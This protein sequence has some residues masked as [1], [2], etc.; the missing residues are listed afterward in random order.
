[1]SDEL[2]PPK[3]PPVARDLPSL[4]AGQRVLVGRDGGVVS[5]TANR[6]RIA[7]NLSLVAVG[8]A[9]LIVFNPVMGA[10]VAAGM[11]IGVVPTIRRNR[12][13][14]EIVR[15]ALA[16][17]LD[18][19]E[20]ALDAFRAPL[21]GGK[22]RRANVAAIRATIAERRG[23]L[24][25]AIG[26]A[27]ECARLLPVPRR[28]FAILYWQNQF[29]RASWLLE[30]GRDDEARDQIKRAGRAPAG[31]WYAMQYRFLILHGAFEGVSALPDDG[32]LHDW[33]RDALRYNH[34]G[35]HLALLAWAFEQRGDADTASHAIAEAPARFLRGTA[36]TARVYPRL[37]AWVGPRLVEAQAAADAAN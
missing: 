30:L 2:V 15:L 33:L 14:R 6:R 27:D 26:H 35:M 10:V 34:T 5:P 32:K 3:P 17:Q 21:L 4:R 12:R 24:A 8:G 16:D 31:E 29:N 19:A 9:A 25:A 11:A 28:G 18:E 36:L 1:M 13:L 20:R 7:L 37:W 22:R 23:N